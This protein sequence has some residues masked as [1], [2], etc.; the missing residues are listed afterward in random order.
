MTD[1][2][3]GLLVIGAA[4]V[5]GVLRYNHLQE[6]AAR[7]AAERVLGAPRGDVLLGEAPAERREP[8]LAAAPARRHGPAD[9]VPDPQL[10]YVIELRIAQGALSSEV[11]AGW[12]PVLQRFAR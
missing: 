2:Q 1:L 12:R 4:A 11:L 3:L 7:R 8:V 9:L 6:R 5:A 10:D